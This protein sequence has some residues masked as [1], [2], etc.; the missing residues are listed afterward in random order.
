MKAKCT[1]LIVVFFILTIHSFSQNLVLDSLFGENGNRVLVVEDGNTYYTNKIVKDTNN[2][3]FIAGRA[4]FSFIG[5]FYFDYIF[6]TNSC[7]VIDSSFGIDGRAKASLFYLEDFVF[8]NENKILVCGSSYI[9]AQGSDDY[10]FPCL[11]RFNSDGSIDSSF[12]IISSNYFDFSEYYFERGCF[13]NIEI[14]PDGKLLCGGFI[15]KYQDSVFEVYSLL[16]RFLPNGIPDSTFG[17]NGISIKNFSPANSN[18]SHYRINMYSPSI[19]RK[20]VIG[21]ASNILKSFAFNNEGV[22]DSTYGLNGIF[23]DSILSLY[24]VKTL[25]IGDTIFYTYQLNSDTIISKKILPNGTLDV[26][27]GTNGL[28]I[29]SYGEF[30]SVFFKSIEALSN[31]SFAIYSIHSGIP[32]VSIFSTDGFLISYF[33]INKNI[34]NYWGAYISLEENGKCFITDNFNGNNLVFNRF[35]SES[36]VP[37][38]TFLNDSLNTNVVSPTLA[39]QWYFNDEAIENAI[40]ST[41]QPTTP[42]NYSVTITDTVEC[43]Q[44]TAT[45]ELETVGMNLYKDYSFVVYPNPTSGHIFIKSIQENKS[46]KMIN[47]TGQVVLEGNLINENLP[48]DISLF[49]NGLYL[50]VTDQGQTKRILKL[51]S[52]IKF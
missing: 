29:L 27:F 4:G 8:Q 21:E 5:E 12:N 48:I 1:S 39:Y 40:Y 46:F 10:Q 11:N 14:Q 20:I 22:V 3:I 52:V 25:L 42:G 2:D 30:N 43:G 16:M 31:N 51:D 23:T 49:S 41:Y 33:D 34:Q 7:G 13:N 18:E 36:L 26:N 35:V 47:S 37:Q 28:L 38:I 6:K 24:E 19:E 15:Q 9:N 32:R 44:Y 17:N 50:I 45:F